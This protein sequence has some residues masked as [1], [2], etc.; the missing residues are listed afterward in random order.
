M[1]PYLQK[2]G[3]DISFVELTD[4]NVLKIKF[5]E[6]CNDCKFKNHTRFIV[7][8][9]IRKYFPDLKEMLDVSE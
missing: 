5:S 6:S 1:R 3:G 9:Q 7:E 4:D 8:K 2:D